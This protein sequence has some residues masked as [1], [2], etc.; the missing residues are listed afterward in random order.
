[1]GFLGLSFGNKKTPNV[2]YSK[3][4]NGNH[5]YKL[6]DHDLGAFRSC[7]TGGYSDANAITLFQ[8][9]P[10][11]FA[12]ID[13][14][15]TRVANGIFQLKKIATDEIVYDNKKWNQ[16]TARPNWRQTFDQVIYNAVVYKYACGNRYFYSHV[17]ESLKKK[18]DNITS[19]WMLPPQL[20][21]PKVKTN[22][23]KFYAATSVSDI[24]DHYDFKWGADSETFSPDLVHHDAYLDSARNQSNILKGVSPL[25]ADEYPMSNLIAVYQARNVIYYKRGALGF[26]VGRKKDESGDIALTPK[27]KDAIRGEFHNT[28]G[29]TGERDTLGITDVPI[30]FVKVSMSIEELKPF[31]ETYNSAAAIYATLGVPRSFIPSKEGVTY[32]NAKNDDRK[33]YQDVAIKEGEN[34]C[35]ILNHVLNLTEEGLYADVSYSH[36]EVLQE[37]KKARAE[38]DAV[39]TTRHTSLYEKGYITK[40]QMLVAIGLEEIPGG[41]IYITDGKSTDPLAVKLGVGGTQAMQSILLSTLPADVKKNAL[42]ILFNLSEQD[43]AKLVSND[44]PPQN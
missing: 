25:I 1:M 40:N 23:P 7:Y 27:E 36:I 37:D 14:I 17:P 22:R 6:T 32:E 10:E 9:I 28:Y 20:T 34:I 15:A 39:V 35:E 43:A 26:L 8:T 21:E 3:D 5:V 29:L 2:S 30:D 4:K 11:V 19:L 12:P 38:T 42:V 16:L 31:E 18:L 33:L 41:D 13:A 44:T 24:V